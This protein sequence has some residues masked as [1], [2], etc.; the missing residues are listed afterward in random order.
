MRRGR[1]AGRSN[2]GGNP[3]RP[4][5]CALPSLSRVVEHVLDPV[6]WVACGISRPTAP[7]ITTTSTTPAVVARDGLG[8]AVGG[9][10]PLTDAQLAKAL[11]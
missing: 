7:P 9:S 11:S 1:V 4:Q 2:P 6:N 3:G 8:L 10:V 5:S